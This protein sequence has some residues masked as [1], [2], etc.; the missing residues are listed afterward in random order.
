MAIVLRYRSQPGLFTSAFRPPLPLAGLW[1]EQLAKFLARLLLF[2]FW[3]RD[4][5]EVRR[6]AWYARYDVLVLEY[7]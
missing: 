6:T 7:L 2:G 5:I 1:T 3:P 4:P